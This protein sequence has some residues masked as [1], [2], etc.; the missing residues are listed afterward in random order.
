MATDKGIQN[1]TNGMAEATT[2]RTLED[3]RRLRPQIMELARQY[4]AHKVSVFGSCVRGEMDAD[5]DIDFLVEFESDFRL[6]DLIRLTQRLEDLVGRKVD[7]VPRHALRRE[8][9]STVLS[10]LQS[11]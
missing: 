7:V 9:E 5:S 11:L 2:I 10:E 1:E 8:L 4:R 3:I 6:N